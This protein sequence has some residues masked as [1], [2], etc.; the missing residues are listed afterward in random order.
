[1]IQLNLDRGE[2]RR[3]PENIVSMSQAFDSEL[4]NF[5]KIS[6]RE[7]LFDVGNGDGNDIIAANISP[8]E[9][10]HSLLITERF[11]CLPQRVTKY[12]L[13]KAVDLLLLSNSP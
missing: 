3:R 7:I 5:T 10:Y 6:D 2:K 8:I 9:K 11:K 4:F 13:R 12:S 1:M